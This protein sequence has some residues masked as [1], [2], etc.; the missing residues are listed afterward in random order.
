[1]ITS[2]EAEAL[3]IKAMDDYVGQC[4]CKTDE[5]V[6]NVLMKLCSVAGVAMSM[7]VGRIDA[8]NRLIGTANF[9]DLKAQTKSALGIAMLCGFLFVGEPVQAQPGTT[10]FGPV[11]AAEPVKK[12][13]PY[14]VLPYTGHKLPIS[15]DPPIDASQY[16]DALQARCTRLVVDGVLFTNC[17]GAK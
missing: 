17:G 6:A 8:V 11:P 3:A 12:A 4:D 7:R 9:I 10:N 16:R 1:M 14:G 15:Q 13:R 5:D 2:Q